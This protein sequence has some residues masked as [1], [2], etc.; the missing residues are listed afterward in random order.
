MQ[1]KTNAKNL[2]AG[3]RER[4]R[5][6]FLQC[7]ING[8]ADHEVLEMLLYYSIPRANT[9]HIAH[10]LLKSAGSIYGVLHATEAELR[11]IS[12]VGDSTIFLLR[13]LREFIPRAEFKPLKGSGKSMKKFEDRMAYFRLALADCAD[14]HLM[15]VC[16]D[17]QLRT[18]R[19]FTI[20]NGSSG[21][22][23]A[24][25]QTLVRYVLSVP[26]NY[27]ILGHNHP[28][29]MAWPSMMDIS[30]TNQI[31]RLLRQLSIEVVDHIIV[32]G[33]HTYSMRQ[34]GSYEPSAL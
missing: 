28:A 20:A 12:G 3:H 21:Y 2:H 27:V 34:N 25:P 10:E 26:C 16:L 9:N 31:A 19:Q 1:E 22:A 6:R 5:Q 30:A 14:E 4:M 23:H 15:M 33:K 11:E 17:D 24:E 8:F 18:I 29:G 13:F 32:A 7:G